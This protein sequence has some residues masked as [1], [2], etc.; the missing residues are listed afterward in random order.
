MRLGTDTI[1]VEQFV[2]TASRIDGTLVSRFPTTQVSRYAVQL[3]PAGNVRK[4]STQLRPDASLTTRAGYTLD[5]SLRHDSL[6]AAK[7]DGDGIHR[8]KGPA[9]AMTVP[10][11]VRS[12]ALYELVAAR[13]FR[14]SNDS[15]RVAVFDQD[16]M[17]IDTL[18]VRRL[19]PDS[20]DFRLMFPRGEHVRVDSAGLILGVSGLGTS[21]KWLSERVPKLDIEAFVRASAE[22][23]ARGASFG[24]LSSRDTVH[25]TTDGAHITIDYGRPSRRGRVI[26][27]ALVPWDTVWRTGANLAT[28]FTSDRDLEIGG[29]AVPAG[30]Y[31]LYTLPSRSGWKLIVNRQTGQN[32]LRYDAAMDLVR[33][34]MVTTVLPSSV[35]R[36]TITV[37]PRAEGGGVVAVSW[38]N[39]E[40]RA[41]FMVP[42]KR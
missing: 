6:F 17:G 28:H 41:I 36:L 31:T 8:W 4:A 21:Y 5:V 1:M 13:L 9:S 7:R 12:L 42:V 34:D 14:S 30:T 18:D 25:A 32:G 23:D 20:I 22:R 24:N 39:L 35:E 27:G 29:A 16:K 38:E 26:F 2:R 15:I 40:A 19:S 3:T 37:T 11:F 10:L 33:V